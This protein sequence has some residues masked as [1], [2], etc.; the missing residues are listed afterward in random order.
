MTQSEPISALDMTSGLTTGNFGFLASTARHIARTHRPSTPHTHTS[1]FHTSHT[2]ISGITLGS[3]H[4]T[5]HSYSHHLPPSRKFPP[6]HFHTFPMSW[7]ST[8]AN[9][10]LRPL[11]LFHILILSRLRQRHTQQGAFI[12]MDIRRGHGLHMS[13]RTDGRTDGRTAQHRTGVSISFDG[14]IGGRDR[15]A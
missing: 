8:A 1:A 3:S 14:G 7:R 11:F 6:S 12:I 9:T 2:H 10:A 13:G 15:T 5:S 4:T